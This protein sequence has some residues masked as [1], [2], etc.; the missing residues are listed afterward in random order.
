MN[1]HN[2]DSG[3]KKM[4]GKRKFSDA[5]ISVV[6]KEIDNGTKVE[7]LCRKLGVI[8][9]TIY[10]WKKRSSGLQAPEI[11]K[12]RQLEEENGETSMDDPD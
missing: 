7:D 9:A 3:N 5:Q 10:N 2:R 6:L 4:P 1:P 12:L 8:E 11:K